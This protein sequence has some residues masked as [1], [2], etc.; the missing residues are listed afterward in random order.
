MKIV[1][2]CEHAF[3][4]IPEKYIH[5]FAED[6]QVLKTHEAYDL[7]AYQIFESLSSLADSTHYQKIGRLLVESNRSTWHKK[8]FSRYSENL[9]SSEK[10]D[11]LDTFYYPYR[12][13]VERSIRSILET[14]QEVLHISVHSFTPKLNNEVRNADIGLLYDPKRK[15]ERLISKVW[16]SL[17]K[18]N[19][20]LTIRSNYPYLGKSDGF[21]TF[22]RQ[23]FPGNYYGIELEVNQK[24]IKSHKMDPRLISRVLKSVKELKNKV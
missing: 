7:G 4:D 8:L 1:L 10:M 23:R 15:R 14:D 3:P 2:T 12:N 24:W 19:S 17:L 18:E 13:E 16:K 9:S 22:L 21:T 20:D 6:K 5:L 11:I